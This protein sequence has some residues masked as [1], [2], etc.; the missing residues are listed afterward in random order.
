MCAH[1]DHD[2]AVLFATWTELQAHTREAH[3]PVCPY[4]ECNGRTFKTPA[5][6]RDH[7]K[8]HA[9]REED[10][11]Q[12]SEDDIAPVLQK[13]RPSRR[14]RRR[15]DVD[16]AGEL[17]AE[18]PKKLA[19]VQ[20]GSAGKMYA[21]GTPGCG[22]T[23]KTQ[24][25]RDEHAQAAHAK[26]KH[27]CDVCGRIYRRPASLKR[28]QADGWCDPSRESEAETEDEDEESHADIAAELLGIATAPGGQ[29]YRPW[30]CPYR[31][32]VELHTLG[33]Q[34]ILEEQQGGE[35]EK[36]EEAC[37]E[38]FFR[39]YDVRRHLGAV[40]GVVVG[41][42]ETRKLLLADGQRGE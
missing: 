20:N 18:G 11:A 13:K 7:L 16:D 33:E 26:G 30:V 12:A 15:S 29:Q 38:R 31:T 40:H 22:K 23:Y 25:A 14:K 42:E 36:G 37:S 28:H 34:K 9:E 2:T 21:C 27:R 35:E 1:A 5:R 39:V 3:P 17:E 32:H 6:L 24:Y 10:L 8:V 4:E 41:D 19:R